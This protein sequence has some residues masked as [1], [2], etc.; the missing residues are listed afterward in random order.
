MEEKLKEKETPGEKA[1]RESVFVSI[2]KFVPLFVF[3]LLV[4]VFKLDLLVAAPIATLVAT[5]IYILIYHSNF[6]H[7]FQ[8]GINAAKNIML[9]FFILMFAYG[10]A[11]CFMATGVGASLILLALKLGVTA[12]TIA[13][14]AMI[15]TCL[16]SVATGSSWGT[17]AACAP[18]FLWLNH[19][20]GGDVILTVCAIAGGSCF[21]DNIGMISDVTVL[22]CGMQDVKIIDRIK[23]Q[24]ALCVGCLL[25]SLVIYYV[26]GLHLP[27]VQGDTQ[28]ALSAIPQD[29]IE[30]LLKERPSAV[31]LLEQVRVGIPYY[32]VIPMLVVVVLSFLGLHTLLCLGFGMLSSLILGSLAGTVDISSWLNEMLFVGF[33]DAGGW[34][35]VMMM[36]V[37]AFGGI[38]NAM[39]AF[40][41]LAKGVV[42]MSR[43]VHQL[44]GWCGVICLLGNVALA[45]EAAQIATMSPIIRKIVEKNVETENEKDAYT[46]RLRLATFTSS[47]GIYGSELIPWHCFPVF[48]A[49]IANAVYPIREGGFSSMD[50]ISR[51]YLSFLI[52]GSIL[53]LTF[54][55]WDKIVPGFALPKTARLKKTKD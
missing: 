14:V 22:S 7:S 12:R 6:E 42:K 32:M 9:I 27:N 25:V 26:A 18:I 47:M 30:A 53:L 55:G 29:A 15:V 41:P 24:M 16:L 3:A 19:L 48:F 40:D 45:D 28:A 44:M 20:I 38:M 31:L 50:I 39:N 10:V 36:W 13:P 37:A 1:P 11:E 8:H 21:G 17:F 4:I 43:N 46:L 49:S 51:N 5:F 2:I 23:H 52:V 34:V 54:T 35:I 33:S